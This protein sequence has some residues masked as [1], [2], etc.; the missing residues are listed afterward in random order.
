MLF[1]APYI[2]EAQTMRWINFE[3]RSGEAT[4]VPFTKYAPAKAFHIV[5]LGSNFYTRKTRQG[6]RYGFIERDFNVSSGYFIFPEMIGYVVLTRSFKENQTFINLGLEKHFPFMG[7]KVSMFLET[8]YILDISNILIV[9]FTLN[10]NV[11]K[12]NIKNPSK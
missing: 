2:C 12:I 10:F 3:A 4:K 11:Y 7:I 6:V 1:L 9:G 8:G 5:S